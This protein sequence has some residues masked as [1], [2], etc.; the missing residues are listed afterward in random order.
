[1][2]VYYFDL[3]RHGTAID[4]IADPDG[5]ELP[6]PAAARDHANIVARELTFQSSGFLD[7][8]WSVWTMS[9]HDGKGTEL[10]SLE[11]TG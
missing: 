7:R 2:P 3:Q 11:M 10:F 5:T 1:M 6:G 4:T 9:V 8:N